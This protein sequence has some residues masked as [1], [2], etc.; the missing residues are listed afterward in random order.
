[1]S[2]TLVIARHE[3]SSF[4]H[5]LVAYVALGVFLTGLGLF[6]WVFPGN[7]L[8][9]GLAEM[10]AVFDFGPWLFLLLVPAV[11]MRSLADEF[12]GGTFEW[13]V[14]RPITLTQ[15]VLGK[16]LAA[17][18]LVLLALVPTLSY[19]LILSYL[20][21]PPNNLDSGAV[22]GSYVGLLL[23]GLAFA[24]I[25]LWASSLTDNQM[26]AFLLA[27]F[28]GFALFQGLELVA[29]LPALAEYVQPLM[30]LGMEAHYRSL[31]RGV[32]DSRDVLYFLS[33]VVGFLGMAY[34]S[35]QGKRP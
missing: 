29:G 13:L 7:V 18:L 28:V 31:G 33:V 2:P 34:L 22:A 21:N 35:L 5:S 1:V 25:G 26:V 30:N 20:G 3:V 10:D 27:A 11:T 23:I 6:F 16:Y 32:I 24:A 12:R 4:F 19:Y 14:T 9:T 8:E 17:G 15:L